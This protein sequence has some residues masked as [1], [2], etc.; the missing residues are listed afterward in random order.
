MALFLGF[1]G[2]GKIMMIAVF[3]CC[4]KFWKFII[5][6]S[7]FA[8]SSYISIGAFFGAIFVNVSR[9]GA[10]YFFSSFTIDPISST[11]TDLAC[12]A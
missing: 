4:E 9:L 5:T 2:F 6:F 8:I 11:F 3:Q 7:I 10:L 12:T 1:Y